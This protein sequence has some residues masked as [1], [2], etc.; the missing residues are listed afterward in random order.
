MVTENPFMRKKVISAELICLDI[1]PAFPERINSADILSPGKLIEMGKVTLSSGGA[2]A[3]TGLA[4]KLFGS[5]VTIMGKIGR[6]A[7]GDMLCEILESHGIDIRMIRSTGEDT[8]Y[9]VV[10]AIPGID[11]I[12]LHNPGANN[13]F[14]ADDI[15]KDALSNA[16][17]FHFGYPPLMK[18]MYRND[19]S[20]LIRMVKMIRNS[21][22]AVSLDL[23]A[24][25]PGSEAGSADWKRILESVIPYLD[26]FVPSAEELCFM[27]DRNRLNEWK[28]RANS[29]D[30]TEILD[31]EKD[32]SPLADM[33]MALGCR[34]LLIKCGSA[35]ILLRTARA[36]I[37]DEISDRAGLD[38]IL[39]ADRDI[40]EKPYIPG[41]IVSATGAGDA[42]IAGFLTS[43]LNG[44]IPEDC[45]H[46][47]AAA[48]A[49]CV[50]ACDA[51]SGLRSLSELKKRI[52]AGW[53]KM[54]KL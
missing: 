28:T 20:E 13:T 42:C 48:G 34:I 4:M 33:C 53:K 36:E 2:A 50:E 41:Q 22:C 47:A 12:F 11:R 16:D 39:W 52:N 25:D 14:T 46:I 7:F 5:D 10:L 19:G 15:P 3:N 17:L 54:D 37:L 38:T 49:S 40:F 45:L 23:A 51:L 29:R 21:G 1:T 31:P 8:S 26:F 43:A 18:A 32:I 44:D 9:T 27:L 6:D 30:I 24:V 35:G